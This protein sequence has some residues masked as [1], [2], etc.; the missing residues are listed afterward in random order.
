MDRFFSKNCHP[1]KKKKRKFAKIFF[2]NFCGNPKKTK[3]N[4]SN[5]SSS[6][7]FQMGMLKRLEDMF[8]TDKLVQETLNRKVEQEN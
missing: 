3:N 1:P 8:W 5:L 7:I 2:E 4:M 6:F